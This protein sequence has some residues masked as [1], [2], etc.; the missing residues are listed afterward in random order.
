MLEALRAA[1]M[2][3]PHFDNRHTTFRLAFSNAGMLDDV[4]LAWLN[5]FAAHDLNDAQRLALAYVRHEGRLTNADYRR[6]NPG[7]DSAE[8]TQH[9]AD[10]VRQGLL[11][12]HGTRRWTSYTLGEVELPAPKI[13]QPIEPYRL[14]EERRVI[15]VEYK[16]RS[17]VLP[18]RARP[19]QVRFCILS[20]CDGASLSSH[21][22]EQRLGRNQTYLL[23]HYLSP[24]VAEGLPERVGTS[25]TDPNLRYRTTE[26]GRAW[27]E[28][29]GEEL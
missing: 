28:M 15:P 9:L 10:L 17:V 4:T 19:Q 16:P 13:A 23:N 11:R 5:R 29:H 2:E 12:Q 14:H 3:P 18:R 1:G 24:L 25:L 21:E 22:L 26:M 6:L 20:L 8:V 7:L 27:L